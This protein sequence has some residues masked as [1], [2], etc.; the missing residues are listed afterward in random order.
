MTIRVK[1]L[2][3]YPIKSC[4]GIS[5][6]SLSIYT[7]TGIWVDRELMLVDATGKFISQRTHPQLCKV[8]VSPPNN[9]HELT[10]SIPSH[11]ELTISTRTPISSTV[12]VTV[13]KEGPF[14]AF[15]MG[16]EASDF[17]SSHLKENCRLVKRKMNSRL[18]RDGHTRLGFADGLPILV[19]SVE[20]LELLNSKLTDQIDMNRFRPNIV[21]EGCTP[22]E[23]DT[24]FAA[25][26]GKRGPVLSWQK[27]CERCSVPDVNQ[28]TGELGM[29]VR[30]TLNGYR[31]MPGGV[32]F[33]S[34][35]S[36]KQRQSRG[37]I[38]HV[39]NVDDAVEVFERRT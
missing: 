36:L 12:L 5:V 24:L 26:F 13:H 20:S 14:E 38:P 4:M 33:G 29:D 28:E 7:D 25:R 8:R 30:R 1:E 37:I 6:Q 35:F 32:M 23:E 19:T 39:I 3:Y 22:H 21:L 11:G 27:L 10:I 34:M 9:R 17:F 18:C 16:Q 15:D 2:L 31:K